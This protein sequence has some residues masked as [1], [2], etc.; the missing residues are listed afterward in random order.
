MRISFVVLAEK[1]SFWK[2]W[3]CYAIMKRK[4]SIKFSFFFLKQKILKN[5]GKKMWNFLAWVSQHVET[6]NEDA[7]KYFL[8][9]LKAYLHV[10]IS[11]QILQPCVIW[12]GI[13][14]LKLLSIAISKDRNLLIFDISILKMLCSAVLHYHNWTCK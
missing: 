2:Q 5:F 10:Q 9:W 7:A 12:T 13:I 11:S 3:K 14:L 8:P 6:H 4:C 1:N